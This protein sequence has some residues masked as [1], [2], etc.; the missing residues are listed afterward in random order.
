MYKNKE[1]SEV[2]AEQS[3]ANYIIDPIPKPRP[4][5]YYGENDLPDIERPD[6]PVSNVINVQSKL[7]LSLELTIFN[8]KEEN[9]IKL[10]L[11]QGKKYNVTYITEYGLQKVTGVLKTIDPNIPLLPVRYIGVSNEVTDL[12]YIVI[13]DSTECKSSIKKIFIRSIRDISEYDPNAE[14]PS[15]D[16]KDPTNPDDGGSDIP[17]AEEGEQTTTP[18]ENGSTS[19]EENNG[20]TTDASDTSDK[21]SEVSNTETDE[22]KSSTSSNEEEQ[23]ITD[24]NDS[25]TTP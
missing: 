1:F 24:K 22:S 10:V 16:V 15:E 20:G 14:K 3:V 12:C 21:E 25:E 9:D 2:L 17:P 18:D 7:L 23:D 4:N 5:P 11:E 6:F 19:T 13:D 8:V